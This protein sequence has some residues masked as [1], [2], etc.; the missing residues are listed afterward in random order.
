MRTHE[1]MIKR[2]R[3]SIWVGDIKS[4]DEL[5]S[6]VDDGQFARDYDFAFIPNRREMFASNRGLPIMELLRGA[7]HWT[8]FATQCLRR[9]EEMGLQQ[10]NAILMAYVLEYLPSAAVNEK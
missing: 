9:T 1:E 7:S 4:E 5:V 6:Y 3:V 2:G 10:A 8:T